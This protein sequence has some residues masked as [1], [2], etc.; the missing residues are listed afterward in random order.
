MR[1]EETVYSSFGLLVSPRKMQGMPASNSCSP[2]ALS[3]ADQV[4]ATA[5]AAEP[6]RVFIR[7]GKKSHGPGQHEHEL[8]LRDWT[9]LLN[10][11]GANYI[12]LGGMAINIH[13]YTRNTYD[14]DLLIETG[15]PNETKVLDAIS[16]LPEGAARSFRKLASSPMAGMLGIMVVWKVFPFLVAPLFRLVVGTLYPGRYAF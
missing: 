3:K 2:S 12:V 14:I 10:E 6:L 16:L 4:T 7:G 11:R 9:R 13:G 1:T 8:F 5:T 15:I